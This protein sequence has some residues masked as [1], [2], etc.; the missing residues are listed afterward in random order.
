[1]SDPSPIND[2]HQSPQRPGETLD[3]NYLSPLNADGSNFPCKG[4]HLD[5]PLNVVATYEAGSKHTMKL[6]G[7]ATHGGGS[8]Q[9]SLSCDDGKEFR[10]IESM[11]GGC[12]LSNSYDFTVPPDVPAAEKCLLA[13]TWFN[14]IGNREMYMNCAVVNIT[15]KKMSKR[16]TQ[17]SA[18][19]ALT[20]YPD[21][22]VANLANINSCKVPETTDVIFDSPGKQVLFG[23]GDNASMKPSF[24]KGQCTSKSSKSAGS[25]VPA[26]SNSGGNSNGGGGNNGQWTPDN[27]SGGSNNGQWTPPKPSTS[28]P[29]NCNDGQYHPACW[30]GTYHRSVVQNQQPAQQEGQQQAQ[31]PEENAPKPD[32]QKSETKEPDTEVQ[33]E[34]DAYLATLYGSRLARRYTVAEADQYGQNKEYQTQTHEHVHTQDCKHDTA[35]Y[36]AGSHYHN[37]EDLDPYPEDGIDYSNK[38]VYETQDSQYH[39]DP[40]SAYKRLSSQERRM[41]YSKRQATNVY[42]QQAA[43]QAQAQTAQASTSTSAQPASDPLT[44]KSYGDMTDQEKFQAFL[45][46]IVELSTNVASL[47]KYAAASSLNP[48]I[49]YYP[50][51]ST[52]ERTEA[53]T[54][55]N[56]QQAGAVPRHARRGVVYPGPAI[57]SISASG[58]ATDA[59][60]GFKAWFPNLVQGLMT[61]RQLVDAVTSPASAESGDGINFFDALL[62]GLAKAFGD[63]F[64]LYGDH[65]ET[66][67]VPAPS[68]TDADPSDVPLLLGEP[69]IYSNDDFPDFEIPDLDGYYTFPPQILAP[70][71]PVPQLLPG[72]ELGPDGPVWVGEGPDPLSDASPSVVPSDPSATETAPFFPGTDV[73][74]LSPCVEPIPERGFN[75]CFGGCNHTASEIAEHEVYLQTFAAEQAAY[76]ACLQNNELDGIAPPAGILPGNSE[77]NDTAPAPAQAEDA[78]HRRPRPGMSHPLIPYPLPANFSGPFPFNASQGDTSP[79]FP[80][81]NATNLGNATEPPLVE[82]QPYGNQTLGQLINDI[83]AD[84]DVLGPALPLDVPPVDGGVPLDGLTNGTRV[85]T[86]T[87]TPSNSS[88]DSPPIDLPAPENPLQQAAD[89]AEDGVT[90]PTDPVIVNPNALESVADALPWFMGPGPV[91]VDPAS[92]ALATPTGE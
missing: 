7:S 56:A 74:T 81:T 45:R 87:P 38:N 9:M 34:L 63:P 54:A 51:A 42:Q 66:D 90:V 49:P 60:E 82:L 33:H 88:D 10:V 16:D 52:Y 14:K 35:G 18:A 13:W 41:A 22:F 8:C 75:S 3:Y 37:T 28:K 40:E 15:N 80:L 71:P 20:K 5:T 77:I 53:S 84:P 69:D 79:P 65:P 72:Y 83:V 29:D 6:R 2:P 25:K 11:M 12:P 50:P 23:N 68:S 21:L 39:E 91:V 64:N 76:E 86:L 17:V 24:A 61:K 31:Q 78:S 46:R 58:E 19:K 44:E 48:P 32:T 30:G 57:G 85:P 47:I 26:S 4:Y 59:E 70:E 43:A 92:S 89:Q 67:P 27:N 1:M 36:P 55:G 73:P 62:A